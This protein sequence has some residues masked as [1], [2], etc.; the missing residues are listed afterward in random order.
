[1]SEIREK[2]AKLE[3]QHSV[4]TEAF[5]TKIES[6][7]KKLRAER[8]MNQRSKA[9]IQMLVCNQQLLAS[10]TIQQAPD[11]HIIYALRL[12]ASAFAMSA[13]SVILPEHSMLLEYNVPRGFALDEW[14][15]V[16]VA[17]LLT[18][19]HFYLAMCQAQDRQSWTSGQGLLF[20]LLLFF[21]NEGHGVYLATSAL[22]ESQRNML[23][24]LRPSDQVKF[25]VCAQR[26]GDI[27]HSCR[28][29][30]LT[31]PL[32]YFLREN[33]SN[34]MFYGSNLALMYFSLWLETKHMD[35]NSSVVRHLSQDLR[36][37]VC[38]VHG[39]CLAA[40]AI[41]DH[42]VPLTTLFCLAVLRQSGFRL[43]SNQLVLSYLT[44]VSLVTV[45]ILVLWHVSL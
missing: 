34:Y 14:F 7:K 21:L 31:W 32:V 44:R 19:A 6:L 16:V 20:V 4:N 29:D 12:L 10:G 22:D 13:A 27:T 30:R 23:V 39:V 9:K 38:L 25:I 33:F 8:A 37:S 11:E 1:M 2:A 17:A 28:S 41:A 3:R 15:S 5:E 42:V 26:G 18:Y 35:V 43:N 24:G 40:M 36:L 45:S